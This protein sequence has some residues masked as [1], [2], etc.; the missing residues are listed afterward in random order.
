MLHRDAVIVRQVVTWIVISP[1]QTCV[2]CPTTRLAWRL[3][4]LGYPAMVSGLEAQMLNAHYNLTNED[5]AILAA[6]PVTAE[7]MVIDDIA[8]ARLIRA[9]VRNPFLVYAKHNETWHT[10]CQIQVRLI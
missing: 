4:V 5:Y 10:E 1:R 8:D 7:S 9:A 6:M 2:L 3:H